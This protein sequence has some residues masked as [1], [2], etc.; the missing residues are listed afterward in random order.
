MIK[1]DSLSRWA[2][3]KKGDVLTLHGGAQRRIRLEVNS[4][5]RS[6]LYFVNDDGETIFLAAP[7][8][9]DVVEFAAGGNVRL[10]T[11]DDDVFIYTSEREPTFTIIEDAVV[12]TKI[13]E[14]SARNPDLEHMMYLQQI[15]MDRRFAQ[16]AND[17][18]QRV[19]EAY[20]AGTKSRLAVSE[21]KSEDVREINSEQ[22]QSINNGGASTGST[23]EA[24]SS[25]TGGSTETTPVGQPAPTDGT[26][27]A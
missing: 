1:L 4:P 19:N 12:F 21:P 3:L 2:H 5:K 13:A 9:R 14:R 24:P 15:N 26:G 20:E 8:R 25:G 17:M 27:A 18:Q 22:S 11:D 10:T 7:D 16:M 23:G 6:S